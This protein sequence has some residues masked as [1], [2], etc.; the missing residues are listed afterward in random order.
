[1]PTE[2]SGRKSR[3]AGDIPA[4][5]KEA[6]KWYAHSRSTPDHKCSVSQLVRESVD[7]YLRDNREDLPEKAKE[8]LGSDFFD[9]DAEFDATDDSID[10]EEIEA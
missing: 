6:L 1:M 10:L 9:D 3:V 4:S 2:D 7:Q 5:Q 8:K